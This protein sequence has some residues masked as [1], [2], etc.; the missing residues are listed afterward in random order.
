MPRYML[1][2]H[3]PANP[4][5]QDLGPSELQ[6]IFQRYKD[7]ADRTARA[8]NLVG[9]Q[10]L[11]DRTGRVLVKDGAKK[12]VVKDGPYAE[13]KEVIGGY[14]T[15]EAKDFDEAVAIARDCPHLDWFGGKVEI[16][17]FDAECSGASGDAAAAASAP[18]V[19]S[20]RA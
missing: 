12:V 2:L 16:R 20:A 3:E 8:G 18:A 17:A 6:A 19:A 11:E 9:G 10:K 14:F 7:W 5:I 1:L 13:T 4:P 15:I